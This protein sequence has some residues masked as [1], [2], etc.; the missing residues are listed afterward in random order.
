MQ[1]IWQKNWSLA[2][3]TPVPVVQTVAK[4]GCLDSLP[5]QRGSMSSPGSRF[6]FAL[7]CSTS[8]TGRH[9][10]SEMIWMTSKNKLLPNIISPFLLP[11]CRSS[12]SKSCDINI[13]VQIMM[14]EIQTIFFSP[15]K[16]LQHEE[17]SKV[18]GRNEIIHRNDSASSVFR[19]PSLFFSL[20]LFSF[21]FFYWWMTCEWNGKECRQSLHFFILLFS[22]LGEKRSPWSRNFLDSDYTVFLFLQGKEILDV[23]S[24]QGRKK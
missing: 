14:K 2:R 12:H 23:I 19:R 24:G 11:N 16:G 7:P 17:K 9:T 15:G 18:K 20:L 3:Y 22:F 6:L 1:R 21:L 13:F 10:S 8:F 5:A 4:D